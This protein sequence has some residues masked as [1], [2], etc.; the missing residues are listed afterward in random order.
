MCVVE[1]KLDI[2]QITM[3]DDDFCWDTINLADKFCEQGKYDEA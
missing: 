2:D 1:L 3:T